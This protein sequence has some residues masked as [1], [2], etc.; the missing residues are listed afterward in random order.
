[1]DKALL[2]STSIRWTMTH[3]PS[4][5]EAKQISFEGLQKTFDDDAFA[6]HAKAILQSS[7]L[8]FFKAKDP[9]QQDIDDILNTLKPKISYINAWPELL[10][11][12]HIIQA[13]KAVGPESI[14]HEN[15]ID[16]A[17]DVLYDR[18]SELLEN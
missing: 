4:G 18:V 17:D 14:F 10:A 9:T 11:M 15:F 3:Y 12:F 13:A 16:T 5:N 8:R 6:S 1:M 7:K 2:T